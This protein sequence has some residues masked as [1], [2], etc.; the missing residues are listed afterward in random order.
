MGGVRWLFGA[1]DGV[2]EWWLFGVGDG[3]EEWWLLPW[4][5]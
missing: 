3:E 4:W 1:G 2:E 5:I